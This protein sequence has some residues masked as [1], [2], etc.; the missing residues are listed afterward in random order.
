[1]IA[2]PD[3]RRFLVAFPRALGLGLTAAFVLALFGTAAASAQEFGQP[4]GLTYGQLNGNRFVEGR[5]ELAESTRLD[6]ELS[7]TP[8]WLTA[9]PDGAATMWIAV[10]DTG[11]IEAFRVEGTEVTRIAEID[12]G[13]WITTESERY[14]G[15]HAGDN[16][17]GSGAGAG[18]P[19]GIAARLRDPGPIAVAHRG[20]EPLILTPPQAA[21]ATAAELS[22]L[23]HPIPVPQTASVAWISEAGDLL[24][25]KIGDGL[26][27]FEIDAPADA[28]PV[29]DGTGRIA[30]LSGAT[31]RYTHGALGDAIEASSVT[32]VSTFGTPR[33]IGRV[34]VAA[35]RVV[36][37]IAPIWTDINGD[38]QADLIVT[39]SDGASG[40]RIGAYSASGALIAEGDP[41]GR[42]HRW[43][44]QLAVGRFGIESGQDQLL[45]AMRTPHIDPVIE[46]YRVRG[47]RLELVEQVEH[48]GLTS[49]RYGSRNLDI[50]LAGNFA[51]GGGTELLLPDGGFVS[52]SI[53]QRTESGVRVVERMPAGGTISTNIAAA[54]PRGTI[55]VGVGRSDDVLRLWI[56]TER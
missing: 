48:T 35:G 28:R 19:G 14:A 29:T 11:A 33:I 37:G 31:E 22:E 34:A 32:V 1:M 41:V 3:T 56:P 47:E 13:P 43:L 10:L 9:L 20:G 8:V 51:D 42:G 18:G 5:V 36:E 49:H 24:V 30:V 50:V 25:W 21:G 55:T 2:L 15:D 54:A 44:H 17:N 7:E 38:R 26:S 46:F 27:R 39:A 40:S 45:A 16:A 23:S 6:I 52:L 12:Q 53:L 4:F